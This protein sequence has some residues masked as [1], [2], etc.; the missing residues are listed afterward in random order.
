MKRHTFYLFIIAVLCFIAAV[1]ICGKPATVPNEA[2]GQ[3]K[4]IKFPP[5]KMMTATKDCVIYRFPVTYRAIPTPKPKTPTDSAFVKGFEAGVRYGLITFL[6][7]PTEK[8]IPTITK[9]AKKWYY[10]LVVDEG[11]ILMGD[12]ETEIKRGVKK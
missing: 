11:K 7:D 12:G 5:L 8:D 2:I 4:P 3:M 1:V 10:L 6:A 9:N